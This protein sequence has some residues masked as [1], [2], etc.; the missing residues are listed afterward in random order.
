MP[1]STRVPVLISDHDS[2][3]GSSAPLGVA[4]ERVLGIAPV[5]MDARHFLNGGSGRLGHDSDGL[6][7]EVPDE[8]IL[9]R[10][11]ILFVYDI[12][13]ARRREF[14]RFQR[15]LRRFGCDTVSTDWR[16]WR[17][18]TEKDRT[19]RCF[20][21]HKI[22]HMDTVT[23]RRPSPAAAA[24]CFIALGGDVWT[25]PTVG[26]G[27]DKVFHVSSPDQL[28]RAVA[29]YAAGGQHWQMARDARNFDAGGDRQS[30]RV[31]VLD[32]RLLVAVEHRQHD[33]D[34]PCNEAR[35]ALS[36]LLSS[37]EE[38]P[39]D[40]GALAAAAVRAVGLRFGGVDLAANGAVFE[41]NVHPVIARHLESV[42]VPWV[43]AQVGLPPRA[44]AA[45][46]GR[47]RSA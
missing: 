11:S 33:P 45:G 9:I 47:I 19:V 4:V 20:R 31:V 5:M 10:A 32:G 39:G 6:I 12:A 13:P 15:D 27:G 35:G 30:Y 23:L 21:R 36:N 44:P 38:L 1:V 40:L 17:N 43:R 16:A 41:V 34:A 25:R 28:L 29:H 18:A 46:G 2:R 3:E 7:V 22:P 24:R 14:E 26:K 37:P 8:D 42:A